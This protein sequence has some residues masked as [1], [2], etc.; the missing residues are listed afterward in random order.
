ME[1]NLFIQETQ[2]HIKNVGK[3]LSIIIRELMERTTK[4]DMSKIRDEMERTVFI[5]YTPKL[6]ESTYG[7]DEYKTF[8]KEMGKGL[9]HHYRNNS[10]HPEFYDNG[11][12]GMNLIDLVEMLCD[13]KAATLRHLN[14]DLLKSIEQNQK[15]FGYGDELKQILFNTVPILEG[16]KN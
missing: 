9:E 2:E 1:K 10:H 15:R 3:F 7:S 4:H 5:E 14:G 12:K 11:I 6:K 13:W 8:L 16:Q